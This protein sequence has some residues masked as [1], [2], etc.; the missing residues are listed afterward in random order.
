METS[1]TQGVTSLVCT[2]ACFPES[3]V[4]VV[5]EVRAHH[6]RARKLCHIPILEGLGRGRP[7]WV[8]SVW[9]PLLLSILSHIITF[10]SC[11]FVFELNR[12][13]PQLIMKPILYS[14]NVLLVAI[15]SCAATPTDAAERLEARK[16][17]FD[18]KDKLVVNAFSKY[19]SLASSLCSSYVPATTTTE[20]VVS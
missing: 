4:H 5:P 7:S 2:D 19:S 8:I 6:A 16:K 18:C 11:Y 20:V 12:L 9:G 14:I 3:S 10:I 13:A 1:D 15:V 17:S